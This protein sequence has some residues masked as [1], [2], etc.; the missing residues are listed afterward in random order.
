MNFRRGRNH[1]EPEINLIPLIDVL[2]VI[3]IFLMVTTTY[4]KFSGLEINLPTADAP[5]PEQQEPN[6]VNVVVTAT[7]DV[8]INRE[9][10]GARDVAAISLALK[11]ASGT[12]KDPVVVINA[13]AKTSH[14]SV[15]DVMQAAQ[16][17]GLSHISFATQTPSK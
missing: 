11:K 1:E 6:E 15:I 2:L 12:R 3:L 8:M 9:P 13:D 4:S 7:G 5:P 14:Q 16:Q 10:L 17:A